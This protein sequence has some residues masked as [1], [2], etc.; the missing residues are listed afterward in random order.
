MRTGRIWEHLAGIPEDSFGVPSNPQES[1]GPS[2]TDLEEPSGLLRNPAPFG[3]YPQESCRPLR[4]PRSPEGRQIRVGKPPNTRPPAQNP[5]GLAARGGATQT[6]AARGSEIRAGWPVP[7]FFF[8]WP[9]GRL[10]FLKT[11]SG[12]VFRFRVGWRAWPVTSGIFRA[13]P[14]DG[15]QVENKIRVGLPNR[16][17]AKTQKKRTENPA[18]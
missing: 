3:R 16:T 14:P 2:L 4:T 5:G 12:C 10:K 8:C 13:G 7:F 15:N 11:D 1:C 18:W 9:P 6:Q 17:V